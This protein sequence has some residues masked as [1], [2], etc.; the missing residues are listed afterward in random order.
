MCW[1]WKYN[2]EREFNHY[3]FDVFNTAD[4]V[5]Q[6]FVLTSKNRF[7]NNVKTLFLEYRLMEQ[8]CRYFF[9][10]AAKLFC[11][12][13]TAWETPTTLSLHNERIMALNYPELLRF[14]RQKRRF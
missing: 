5:K 14:S 3:P 7:P 11:K 4:I 2:C 9:S 6:L 12:K 1:R 8:A 13:R 10:S